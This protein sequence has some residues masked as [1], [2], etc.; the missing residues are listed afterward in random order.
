MSVRATVFFIGLLCFAALVLGGWLVCFAD[1]PPLDALPEHL[2]TPSVRIVDRHGRTL[3]EV[4]PQQGGRHAVAALEDIPL[5]LQQAT[6]ATEDRG[7]YTH[8]GVDLVGVLRALWINLRGGGTR[9]GGST[10][11]QQVARNLLL[12]EGERAQRSLRRKLRE[13]LLAWQ[14]T[15]RFSKDEI[16]ALYLNQTYY[17]GMAYGAEA[18]AQTFFG[19]PVSQLDLA[20]CALLA[21]LP[22]APAPYN[23]FTDFEA[24]KTRQEVVLGLMLE[25]GYIDSEQ[26]DLAA[27]EQLVLAETPY[28]IEAPHFVMMARNQL[29]DRFTPEQIYASGGLVARTTLDLDWQRHAERAVARQ[30]EAL[31]QSQDGL[32]HNVNNAALVALDPQTGE[33]LALVGS[34]DYFDAASAGA[35]NMALS[36]R[37]P[38]SALKPLVYAAAFEAGAAGGG[39]TAATMLLD[40]RTSFITHD[41]KAY[42]PANY[43]Q[44]E[45]GPVLAREALGSSLNIPAV[46]A[47]EHIGLERLFELASRL[48]ITT[49]GDP[50]AYDLSLALGGGEVRLLELTAAYGAFANGGYRLSPRVILEVRDSQGNLLYSPPPAE[51]LRVLD[52]RVAWLISDILSDNQARYLG[53]GQ[54]S[55]LRLDRPAAVKTGTTSNFHD[56]WTIGYTPDLVVGVWTGNTN[57]EPMRAVNGL[58]GA[59]PVWHQFM[60]AVLSGQ[61]RRDFVQPAGFARLEVCALSGLLPS[62]ACPYRRWEWFIQGT[63]P[64]EYDTFYQQVEIDR[65]TGLLADENTP[66]DRRVRRVVLDLPPQAQPWARAQGLALYQDYLPSGMLGSSSSF[67]APS[68]DASAPLRLVSPPQGSAYRLSSSF[69]AGAQRILIEAVGEP[70]LLEVTLIVDGQPLATLSAAPYQAWWTLAAGEHQA[71]AEC[72]RQD[73]KRMVSE[74][75]MFFVEG[76]ETSP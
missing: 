7:F 43:D 46:I 3:Y 10:I 15:Q 45:H 65:A 71:W 18:A 30:L 58:T 20:E 12:D 8:P 61:P 9:A 31:G 40:V 49:L 41:G 33:I 21:G 51:R 36:P 34:P 50:H 62:E 19:K 44:R 13:S 16:L 55:I 14:L 25:D 32:G 37:Q 26:R 68:S 70:G 27:R 29:D 24:A 59:A 47:L 57:Y 2:N 67:S 11:T 66:L 63:Q 73:G 35:I 48:G 69:D 6:I 52:E 75:V 1:L 42:T 54:N 5:S 28:P 17:G 56:N 22:Q 60:R 76:I 4:L 23:P 53:F 39:W 38:G 64:V 74:I 72:L